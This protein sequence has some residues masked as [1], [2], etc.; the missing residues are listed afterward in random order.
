MKKIIT[1]IVV[2]SFGKIEAQSPELDNLNKQIAA[3]ELT[4]KKAGRIADSIIIARTK[5]EVQQVK[6]N[7]ISSST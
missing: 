5:K 7:K 1:L 6:E 4:I 3:K 2:I